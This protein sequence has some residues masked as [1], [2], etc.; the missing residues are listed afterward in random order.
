MFEG[1]VLMAIRPNHYLLDFMG[2]ETWVTKSDVISM[3][4]RCGGETGEVVLTDE[5]AIR[6]GLV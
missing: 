6:L 3:T 1:V 4:M 5:S 2:V